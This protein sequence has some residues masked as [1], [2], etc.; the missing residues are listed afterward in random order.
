MTDYGFATKVKKVN[1][2]AASWDKLGADMVAVGA[3]SDIAQVLYQSADTLG[4]TVEQ[5]RGAL[6]GLCQKTKF[7]QIAFPADM[8]T[9]AKQAIKPAK[10]PAAELPANPV[11]DMN[12][13]A[14]M[15]ADRLSKAQPQET[16]DERKARALAARE[17][18]RAK[19]NA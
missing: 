5:A 7:G 19:A 13:L 14:D 8:R 12:K 2:N 6:V 4:V 17:A 11:F 15:V 16:A 1:V 9:G 3:W 10:V 18:A